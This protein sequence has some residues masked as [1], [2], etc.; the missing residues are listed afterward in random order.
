[1]KVMLYIADSNLVLIGGTGSGRKAKVYRTYEMDL[2]IDCISGGVV[3]NEELFAS[4]L[5]EFFKASR[6]KIKKLDIVL[7]TKSSESIKLSVPNRSKSLVLDYIQREFRKYRDFER[8]CTY[9]PI[10]K[11]KLGKTLDVLAGCLSTEALESY[12]NVFEILNIK[13]G[14]VRIALPAAVNYISKHRKLRKLEWSLI[15]FAEID[16]IYN[17]LLKNGEYY[18][19][20]THSTA[21]NKDVRVFAAESAKALSNI[22][23]FMKANRIPTEKVPVFTAGYIDVYYDACVEINSAINPDIKIQRLD[24]SKDLNARKEDYKYL[25]GIFSLLKSEKT[26]DLLADYKRVRRKTAGSRL[27]DFKKI[28]IFALILIIATGVFRTYGYFYRLSVA[29][30]VEVAAELKVK[31]TK[32]DALYGETLEL[33]NKLNGVRTVKDNLASYPEGNEKAVKALEKIAGKLANVAVTGYNADSGI[34]TCK[35]TTD[36]VEKANKFV[37]AL[38][39]SDIVENVTYSGFSYDPKEEV[40]DIQVTFNLSE[41]AGK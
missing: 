37:A 29:D 17:I 14:S 40:Y 27:D 26:A 18:H 24:I 31:A 25:F 19:I 41:T 2:P 11:G 3:T 1:M 30:E 39:E 21:S 5:K 35:A 7:G 8:A 32:Y 33:E 16:A 36:N 4:H 15:Q 28:L 9:L 38:L 13:V 22:L 6:I 23:Q 12:L 20:Y 10:G 34:F